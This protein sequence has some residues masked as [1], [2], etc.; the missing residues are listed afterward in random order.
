MLMLFALVVNVYGF[1]SC[2]L[3]CFGVFPIA[4]G[5]PIGLAH[6][7][8]NCIGVKLAVDFQEISLVAHIEW[9]MLI[10]HKQA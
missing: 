6:E 4:C 8:V 1:F 10:G 3:I 9:C 2:N 7:V 5:A